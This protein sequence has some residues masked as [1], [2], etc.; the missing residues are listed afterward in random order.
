MTPLTGAEL[1]CERERLGL[2]QRDLAR[3]LGVAQPTLTRWERGDAPVP[4]WV[5]RHLVAL[6]EEFEGEVV[7]LVR[8]PG[9]VVLVPRTGERDGRPASWWRAVAVEVADGHDKRI[10]WDNESGSSG[11]SEK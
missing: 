4:L 5:V 8:Q 1:E 6:G 11:L 9:D 2:T 7:R 10:A 3:I